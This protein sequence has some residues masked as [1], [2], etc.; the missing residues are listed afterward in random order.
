[1]SVHNPISKGINNTLMRIIRKVHRIKLV[2][3]FLMSF[4]TTFLYS[5]LVVD[6]DKQHPLF[7]FSE[8]V[9]L[10]RPQLEYALELSPD[11]YLLKIIHTVEAGQSKTVTFSDKAICPVKVYRKG[12]KETSY[13]FL[14]PDEIHKNDS[15]KI[16]FSSVFPEEVKIKIHNYRHSPCKGM[17]VC[18][19]PSRVSLLQFA[20]LRLLFVLSLSCFLFAMIFFIISEANKRITVYII[21][22]VNVCLSI[23]AI[24]NILP[25]TSRV[26]F[27]DAPYYWF[28]FVFTASIIMLVYI[29]PRL[30]VYI[31]PSVFSKIKYESVEVTCQTVILIL[32]MLSTPFFI[33]HGM[34]THPGLYPVSVF[35]EATHTFTEI[36][37]VQKAIL[38][39]HI[40]KMNFFN[41]FGTPLLG[42]PVTNPFALH[43]ISYFFFKP[44]IAMITN[45]IVLSILTFLVLF[46]FYRR[47]N[48]SFYSSILTAF[49]T[50]TAPTYFWF[51]EHHPHQG[52]L[53]YF[54]CIL[55]LI[56]LS[57]CKPKTIHYILLHI[58]FVA[59]FVSSGIVGI[60]LG[61][62]FALVFSLILVKFNIKRLVKIF[63][64]PLITAV[65]L[66]HPHLFYFQK[67]APLTWRSGFSFDYV[68]QY[69]FLELLK[70]CTFLTTIRGY[71]TDFSINYSL[72]VLIFIV[73]GF[74]MYKNLKNN[75][76]FILSFVLGLVPFMG[77]M[78]M[79]RF[80]WIQSSI[81]AIKPVDITRILWFSNIFLMIS[82]GLMFDKLTRREVSLVTTKYLIY[83]LAP[84]LF[85]IGFILKSEESFVNI[86]TH[87]LS[88]ILILLT[89]YALLK[90]NSGRV[91]TTMLLGPLMFIL[92]LLPRAKVYELLASNNYNRLEMMSYAPV[93][94]VECMEPYCR[95]STC[96]MPS[97]NEPMY[98][99]PDQKIARYH[100]FG[101]AGRSIIAHGGFRA[102]LE[103]N[104]LVSFGWLRMLYFFKPG[105]PAKLARFGIRYLA[106]QSEDSSA[107]ERM[108]WQRLINVKDVVLF[109]N[110][111]KPSP[112]YCMTK[113]QVHF[114]HNYKF[115][116]DRVE[117]DIPLIDF[118]NAEIVA[119]F[120]SWPGW[121]AFL[122]DKPV[123]IFT[124]EDQFIRVNVS[125]GKKLIL[126]FAP[127][128]NM[129][130]LSSAMLSFV[131]MMACCFFGLIKNNLFNGF[132]KRS[133]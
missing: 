44:H 99:S 98:A 49:L 90:R 103:Q 56:D 18:F 41:N 37:L 46:F 87:I 9:S 69:T 72:V 65:I 106:C 130:I 82:L 74:L 58:S 52:V 84:L 7:N 97:Q 15:L 68:S 120:I 29:A 129:Y 14:S 113:N 94:F 121:R 28:W 92:L 132:S 95:L 19:R 109:E 51:F 2:S 4:W 100:I 77:V 66:V 91:F 59:F 75:L 76:N 73:L 102:F 128:S 63:I 126:E 23:I 43:A 20:P 114:I 115:F 124:K 50:F 16:N 35:D 5:V 105:F 38:D 104:D 83:L 131:F 48:L 110:S 26:V 118:E 67:I 86:L 33:I 11:H 107:V 70:G 119:T 31:K 36:P 64:L 81:P 39:G 25:F 57:Y 22:I 117:I 3:L 78:I 96:Q 10:S 123:D 89:Y 1:M 71:H 32:A 61:L 79:L 93:E 88:P 30:L 85:L 60:F 116:Y 80:R 53:F 108:G 125:K 133:F 45:K 127:Y 12:N 6:F 24:N 122:D 34:W 42:D 62:P 17:I 13:F 47:R 21:L 54:L 112:F 8:M 40:L 27:I 55:L 111:L 101:S